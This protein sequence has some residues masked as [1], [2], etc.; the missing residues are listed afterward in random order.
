MRRYENNLFDPQSKSHDTTGNFFDL[1]ISK[2]TF[3]EFL[4]CKGPN[5][6]YYSVFHR[7]RNDNPRLEDYFLCVLIS[8]AT[9]QIY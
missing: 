9:F 4:L 2:S 3:P 1:I 7:T 5:E 8:K 6:W